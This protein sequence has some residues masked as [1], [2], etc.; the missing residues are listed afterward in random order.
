MIG[1]NVRKL[2]QD[3][4]L[5]L[6]GLADKAGLHYSYLSHLETGK[7]KP[8]ETTIAKLCDAFSSA[9][10]PMD[11]LAETFLGTLQAANDA[12]PDV[13]DLQTLAQ[14]A[15]K[16]PFRIT[17]ALLPDYE[18][19]RLYSQLPEPMKRATINILLQFTDLCKNDAID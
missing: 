4:G 19:L 3:L 9:G 1:Q 7:S 10:V 8:R 13:Q 17:L 11:V 5:S 16:P 15:A 6:K 14:R 18:V 2:R 12:K